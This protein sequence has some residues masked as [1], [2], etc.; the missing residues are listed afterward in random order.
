MGDSILRRVTFVLLLALL[1]PS[2]RLYA[3]GW[4]YIKHDKVEIL[5]RISPEAT[6]EIFTQIYLFPHILQTFFG[7]EIDTDW[8][9]RV[10]ITS[11]DREFR[12]LSR[13]DQALVIGTFS[14]LPNYNLVMIRHSFL[15]WDSSREII[16]HE[17]VHRLFNHANLPVWADEGLAQYYQTIDFDDRYVTQGKFDLERVRLL[18]QFGF[19]RWEEFFR[20]K[21][22]ADF[23]DQIRTARFYVQAHLLMQ[24]IMAEADSAT[25]ER[26]IDFIFDRSRREFTE[27]EF[28]EAIGMNYR[29][30]Q[31]ALRRMTQQ[32]QFRHFRYDASLLPEVPEVEV[33]TATPYE[34]NLIL[35]GAKAWA[36]DEDGARRHLLPLTHDFPEDPRPHEELYL[37][38]RVTGNSREAN[39]AARNAYERGSRAP[40]ILLTRASQHFQDLAR[41]PQQPYPESDVA[42]LQ[43]FLAPVLQMDA[44]NRRAWRMMLKACAYSLFRPAKEELPFFEHGYRLL[45]DDPETRLSYA[46]LL[47][48]IGRRDEGRT[49]VEDVLAT[50][51]LSE[52]EEMEAHISWLLEVVFP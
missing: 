13:A 3:S 11:G 46:V 8:P 50:A 32:R 7:A 36:R 37:M 5:S 28:R 21:R 19:I 40:G 24:Y 42:A 48:K 31:S 30:L 33:R 10:I 43:Q 17:Y 35:G 44:N 22:G 16:F 51:D 23:D 9:I 29:Q 34:E 47:S 38:H 14:S 45:R 1:L 15:S 41:F 2:G 52:H 4:N 6:R 12:E 25:R 49:I 26:F 39:E 27:A 18:G 20:M